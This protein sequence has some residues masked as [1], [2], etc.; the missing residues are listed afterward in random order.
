MIVSLLQNIWVFA[1]NIISGTGGSW[2]LLNML[3]GNAPFTTAILVF[4]LKA[5]AMLITPECD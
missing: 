4:A 3:E 2:V 1:A 5:I